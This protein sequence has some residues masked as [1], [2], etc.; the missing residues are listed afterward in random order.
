MVDLIA[1]AQGATALK[2]A[3]DIAKTF[4]GLRDSAKLLEQ[5]VE[6]NRQILSA[7]QALVEAREEQATLVQ[8]V[9][10]LEEEI[11]RLKSWETE[12]QKYDLKDLGHGAFAYV[13]NSSAKP[14]QAPHW[15]CTNCY[16]KGKPS[17]LLNTNRQTWGADL[18]VWQC[19]ECPAFITVHY[20]KSPRNP[21]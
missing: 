19:P 14:T 5:S 13:R 10:A 6:L 1:L 20:T 18:H 17:I 7:Q 8:Q 2:T 15:L 3:G 9:R 4:V 12:K 16:S 21:D 11:A